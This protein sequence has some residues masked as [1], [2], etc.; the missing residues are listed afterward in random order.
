MAFCADLT[1]F[2]DMEAILVRVL[3]WFLKNFLS[4]ADI[5]LDLSF[6]AFLISSM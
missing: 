2:R 4:T 6:L 3:R 1:I 5:A